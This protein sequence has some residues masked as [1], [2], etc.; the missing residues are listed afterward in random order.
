M[1]DSEV[2][3]MLSSGIKNLLGNGTCVQDQLSQIHSGGRNIIFSI[4]DNLVV[5]VVFWLQ[6]HLLYG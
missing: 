1:C 6:S 4:L 2:A 3:R 5:C